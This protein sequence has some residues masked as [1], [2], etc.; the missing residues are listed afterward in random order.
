[1]VVDSIRKITQ[2]R[3]FFTDDDH[4]EIF[5]APLYKRKS[6]CL[7]ILESEYK[8]KDPL[9]I[10]EFMGNTSIELLVQSY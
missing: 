8:L 10:S 3:V 4:P 5:E 6:M 7:E 2:Y 9:V 1:M